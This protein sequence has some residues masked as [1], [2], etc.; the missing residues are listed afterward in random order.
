M[1]GEKELNVDAFGWVCSCW[2]WCERFGIG[3]M[4]GFAIVLSYLI[5]RAV[6][7]VVADAFV[8]VA[9]DCVSS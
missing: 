6:V 3:V 1:G 2:S 9:D 4:V 7:V 8:A 5:N